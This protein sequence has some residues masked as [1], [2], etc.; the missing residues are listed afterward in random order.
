MRAV[1]LVGGFGTRLRPLTLDVPKQMLPVV[2]VTMLERVVGRLAEHGV[3]EVVLSLGYRP[4]VFTEAF[5]DGHCAGATIR[6]AVE[7]EPLDTG[8]A[9]AFA[10]RE[11][12]IDETFLA[13]N[14]D[15]LTDMDL[16]ELVA[17]HRATGARGTISLTP[18]DD[19]SRYGVVP[20]DADG[21]V[22]DFVEK[23]APGTA[24]SNWINAGTYVLEPSVLDLVAPGARVSIE[25]EVFPSIAA[26]GDL[27]AVQS[28]AYW[29]DAGTPDAYLQANLDLLSGTRGAP[30]TGISVDASVHPDA[31][32]VDS[33]VG[34]DAKV[35]AGAT[36]ERSVV[37]AGAII[38][39]GATLVDSVV[40]GRATVGA[41]AILTRSL[42]GFDRSV[43][44]GTE[45]IERRVP[46]PEEWG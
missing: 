46:P 44:S 38:E 14:G 25:R 26:D 45:L 24:P 1:V 35:G 15:V 6:Y 28:D 11:A 16:D 32:V 18:V 33:A 4:D 23:P 13:L 3:D 17:M 37:M 2:G 39:D 43:D 22:I 5:P 30:L 29:I 8:G 12:A 10:A 27:F 34:A 41:G 42:V 31:T 7:P 20:T 36:V 19:P 40:G 9:I 21:R